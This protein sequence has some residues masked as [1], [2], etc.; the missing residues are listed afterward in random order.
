MREDAETFA[1]RKLR[2]NDPLWAWWDRAEPTTEVLPIE[3]DNGAVLEELSGGCRGCDRDVS[4]GRVRV[5]L[6]NR[7]AS[8]YWLRMVVCCERCRVASVNAYVIGPA[9]EGGFFIRD[10]TDEEPDVFGIRAALAPNT[11]GGTDRA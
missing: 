8:T 11:T 4:A 7:C 5:E 2:E 1:R 9:S 10:V 3:F 6:R